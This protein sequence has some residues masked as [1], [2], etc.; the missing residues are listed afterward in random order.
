MIKFE[1]A[2]RNLSFRSNMRLAIAA[3]S[4]CTL[5]VALGYGWSRENA[6]QRFVTAPV[7]RGT[8]S[9]VVKSTGTVEAVVSVDV[10][11]ELS[12]RMAEVLV[13]FNDGVKVGQPIARLDQ[14]IFLARVNEAKADLK[15]AQASAEQQ[16]AALDRARVM[17]ETARTANA[18]AEADLMAAQVRQDETERDFHRNLALSKT[19]AISDREFTQSR[20]AR[21]AGGANLRA[22]TAQTKMRAEAIEIADAEVSMAQANLQS[23]QAVIEQREAMLAQAEANL[24]FTEIRAPI[25]GIIIKRAINPGQ[26][27]AVSLEAKT[28]FTIA[29]D[30]RDM[31]VQGRI[32]E[33]DVG[34]LRVGQVV[35]FTVDA[36]PNK[37]FT[38]RVQQI[39]KAP[40]IVQSVV[41]YTAIVAAPNPDL[42]LLPGM[43]ATLRIVIDDTGE[44]LKVPN[45][46]LR[47]QPTGVTATADRREHSESSR[48]SAS[49]VVWMVGDRGQPTPV[50]VT[51][52]TSDDSS[53]Q[54]FSG[55]LVEGQPLIVGLANTKNGGTGFRGVRL[56]F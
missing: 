24:Q 56:G 49:S 17:A 4:L 26:T 39:R 11:S 53:T 18:A 21:D 32:D 45:E 6:D 34:R 54:I 50:A 27:V 35:Q 2:G 5:L 30:L 15:I 19:A 37:A 42:L 7:E 1:R 47:F 51:L 33:A 43:T 14:Q 46:A 12:G 28:L 48:T 31:E 52:G 13:N 10:S 55:S 36:Y 3:I 23:T 29:N 8:I 38:G 44:T 20:A 9:T 22:Q 25:D 16:K 40:E 41:T